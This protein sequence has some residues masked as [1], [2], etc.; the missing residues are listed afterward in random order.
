MNLKKMEKKGKLI[1]RMV[2][3]Y[4]GYGSKDNRDGSHL[5]KHDNDKVCTTITTLVG[6]NKV[7]VEIYDD[8]KED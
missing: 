1:E 8:G 7:V 5:I 4:H 3:E 6:F 2:C